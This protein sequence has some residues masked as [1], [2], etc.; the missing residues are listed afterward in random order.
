MI[1]QSGWKISIGPV[2]PT[3]FFLASK[4]SSSLIRIITIR[5][6][7][8]EYTNLEK[9]VAEDFNSNNENYII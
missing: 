1:R 2:Y 5:K 3:V 7:T 4:T 6:Y 8:K 9:F